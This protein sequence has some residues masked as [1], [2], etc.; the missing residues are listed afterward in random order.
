M[1]TPVAEAIL[2]AFWFSAFGAVAKPTELFVSPSGS[3]ANS[4]TE[5]SPFATLGEARDHLREL[6][7][8]NGLVEGATVWLRE[9]THR[10][11]QTFVLTKEDSGTEAG[12]VVYRARDGE[13]VVVTGTHPL[14]GFEPYKGE[15]LKTDAGAQGFRGKRF[16]QLFLDGERQIRARYPNHDPSLP[17]TGGY[18]YASGEI[19]GTYKALGDEPRTREG[20]GTG[21][22][23]RGVRS[24]LDEVGAQTGKR[25]ALSA[26]ME[27]RSFLEQGLGVERR[28]REG[29]VDG[30]ERGRPNPHAGQLGT[31]ATVLG[32]GQCA[33][34]LCLR[35]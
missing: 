11:K 22:L 17:H 9:G 8:T 26:T 30:E 13:T 28:I 32:G 14:T 25:M 27:Y 24:D 4:G 18:A 20:M 34:A 15:I 7:R 21:F 5:Q 31:M 12:P 19:V 2:T 16:R 6:R 1:R 10:L 33:M 29:L 3:D 35:S 23:W